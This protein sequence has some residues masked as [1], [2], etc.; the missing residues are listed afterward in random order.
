VKTKLGCFPLA[1][2][3]TVSCG[4]DASD[5]ATTDNDPC[6]VT[7]EGG[8]LSG[9]STGATCEYRGVPFAKPPVGPLRFSP[10]EPAAPWEGTRDATRFGATCAQPLGGGVV[11]GTE[12]CLYLNVYTPK[13][14][15]ASK[16]PVMVWIHGG[17]FLNGAGSHYDG[18]LL[19]ESG[20]VVVVTLNYRLGAFG[21][22]NLPELD[23]SRPGAPSGNDGIRDQQLALRWVKANAARF[24]GD[25]DNVTLFGES[26]GSFS[27]CVHWISPSSRSLAQRFVMQSGSCLGF[28]AHVADKPVEPSPG[29]QLVAE[30]CPG[31]ADPLTCLRALDAAAIA[32][33]K[34]ATQG[35]DNGVTGTFH[36]IVEGIPGGVLPQSPP[37]LV[38]AGEYDQEA[39]VIAGTNLNEAGLLQA[40]YVDGGLP[41]VTDIASYR[42]ALQKYFDALTPVVEARYPASSD[43][44]A[45]SVFSDVMT[46]LLMRCP[47]RS[48]VRGAR[49]GGSQRVY[50]YSY[51]AGR[52]FHTD[53]I[54]ALMTMGPELARFQVPE[55]P[56][57][58]AAAMKG[59][60]TRFAAT[61]DP[62]GD[63]APAWPLYDTATDPHLSLND[64]PQASAALG[65]DGC[66]FWD[67]LLAAMP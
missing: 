11:D 54:A 32:A 67:P 50:L 39:E 27:A 30:L 40:P 51:E 8:A 17:S 33:W 25:P 41:V 1:F 48:L 21:S 5:G 42:S 60:W 65:K 62:N 46:D 14:P 20:P 44:D 52:A 6:R 26:A 63:G 35:N 49:A 28:G 3:A 64:P 15:P 10:P 61:G 31:A 47:T 56:A 29:K 13:A 53:E 45:A 4:S 55:P 24:G 22:M 57:A 38:A 23:A 9:L 19:S 34:P 12:D 16:L 37:A 58:L 2:V 7:V 36:P 59:Y 66:D 43:A 18:R